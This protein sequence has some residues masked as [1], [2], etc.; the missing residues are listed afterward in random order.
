MW[1]VLSLPVQF[2]YAFHTPDFMEHSVPGG[3]VTQLS[4]TLHEA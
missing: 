2:W 4:P 3:A 1:T